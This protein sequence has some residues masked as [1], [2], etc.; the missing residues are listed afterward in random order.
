[1]VTKLHQARYQGLLSHPNDFCGMRK[2][3][4]Y[5]VNTASKYVLDISE[6]SHMT[7]TLRKDHICI[8]RAWRVLGYPQV[9]K[10]T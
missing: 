6:K 10:Y 8:I 5:L 3:V 1:M 4:L 7:H 2:R 9:W